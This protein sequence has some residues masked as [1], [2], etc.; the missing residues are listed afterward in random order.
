MFPL[1]GMC[2]LVDLEILTAGEYFSAAW[3][4]TLERSFSRVDSDMVDQLVLGLERS[5]VAG[6]A[7]PQTGVVCLFGTTHVLDGQ[8][9]DSFLDAG[10]GAAARSWRGHRLSLDARR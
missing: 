2:S 6:T 7:K 3:K 5:T 8:V 10:E 9:D 1:T 4:R